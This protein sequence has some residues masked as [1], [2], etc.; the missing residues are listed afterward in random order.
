MGYRFKMNDIEIM[1]ETA[2]ELW[3]AMD[4]EEYETADV[5]FKESTADDAGR[6]RELLTHSLHLARKNNANLTPLQRA[7]LVLATLIKNGEMSAVEL[8][9]V[10]GRKSTAI[11]AVMKPLRGLC[12]KQGWNVNKYVTHRGGEQD[13]K[14]QS[15]WSATEEGSI[16]LELALENIAS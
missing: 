1:C 3:C 11:G 5:P 4:F 2:E 12:K 8:S 14:K 16:L 6:K 15:I 9:E 7:V 10:H 13:G